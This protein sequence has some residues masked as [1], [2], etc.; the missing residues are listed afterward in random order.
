MQSCSRPSLANN[1]DNS[2][3]AKDRINWVYRYAM[4]RVPSHFFSYFQFLV[5]SV[6]FTV[7]RLYITQCNRIVHSRN[8]NLLTKTTKFFSDNEQHCLIFWW[9]FVSERIMSSSVR[10]S[11][12]TFVHPTQP[13][14]IF[15]NV[16][17]PFG[18]LAIQWHPQKILQRSS[19]G[20]PSVVGVKCKRGSQI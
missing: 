8:N 9:R 14:E 1:N 3:T 10:L 2:E 16:S 18:I 20:N 12:V 7:T 4:P 17:T 15:G 5:Q 13:V 11:F 19:Q 6:S